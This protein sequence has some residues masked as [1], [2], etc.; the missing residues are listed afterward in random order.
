MN[1]MAATPDGRM[2]VGYALREESSI[3]SADG[4]L[5]KTVLK[6]VNDL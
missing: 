5:Q 1:N 4:Q 6:D 2:A 3:F